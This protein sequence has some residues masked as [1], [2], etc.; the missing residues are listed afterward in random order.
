MSATAYQ[1]RMSGPTLIEKGRD[2]VITLPVYKDGALVVPSAVVV[3]VWT[4]AGASVVA[5]A[6]GSVVGSTHRAI[7]MR[8]RPMRSGKHGMRG[9]RCVVVSVA[10]VARSK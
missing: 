8:S 9:C 4:A 10:G 3:S 5:A 2:T 1:A 6:S 7:R